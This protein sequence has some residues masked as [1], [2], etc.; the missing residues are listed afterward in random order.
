MRPAGF[1][2]LLS[3]CLPLAAAAAP[4][5]PAR[6]AADRAC[7]DALN[8]LNTIEQMRRTGKGTIDDVG[9]LAKDGLLRNALCKDPDGQIFLRGMLRSE[10]GLATMFHAA[11]PGAKQLRDA[12]PD[13]ATCVSHPDAFGTIVWRRCRLQSNENLRILSRLRPMPG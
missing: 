5:L 11:A 4:D 9:R 2:L 3:L 13:L 12:M 1:L 8:K 7:A 10:S 6:I